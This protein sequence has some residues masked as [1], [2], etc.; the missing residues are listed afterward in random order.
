MSG[1]CAGAL[2][3]KAGYHVVLF[4]KSRGVGGRMSTRR[5]GDTAFNHGANSIEA[6]SLAFKAEL[7]RWQRAEVVAAYDRS[8]CRIGVIGSTASG[9]DVFETAAYGGVPTMNAPLKLIARNLS[10]HKQCRIDSISRLNGTWQVRS[11]GGVDEGEFAAVILAIPAPQASVL[12]EAHSYI[13]DFAYQID[14]APAW[15]AMVTYDEAVDT[16]YDTFYVEGSPLASAECVFPQPGSADKR[17]WVLYGDSDWSAA[18][19]EA[20]ASEVESVLTNAFMTLPG[21]TNARPVLVD[22]HRWR[23]AYTKN[24]RTEASMLDEKQLVAACGDWFRH[25]DILQ[26]EIRNP[27]VLRRGG[28]ERAWLSGAD[29]TQRLMIALAPVK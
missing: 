1:I 8:C 18:H 14:M 23:F 16:P 21:V 20:P 29:I 15:V 17:H 26:G 4:D 19:L 13:A 6:S 12:L 11:E 28:I 22:V 2:L 25:P 7:D 10:I 27:V 24:P 9:G 3:Q 5:R